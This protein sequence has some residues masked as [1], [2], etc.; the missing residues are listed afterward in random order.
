MRRA[1]LL[2]DSPA[3]VEALVLPI[4]AAAPAAGYR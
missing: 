2:G 4:D 1:L 3:D